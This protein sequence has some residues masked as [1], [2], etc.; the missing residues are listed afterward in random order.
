[1]GKTAFLFPGQGSQYVGM[2]SDLFERFPVARERFVIADAV[3]GFFLSE[4]M[5]GAGATEEESAEALKQ[6][7]V[8]Q[9][10]L[11]VHSLA[12]ASVLRSSGMVPQM[13]AGHSL[14]EYSALASAGAITFEAGLEVVRLR[15]RLMADAG[16]RRSGTMAAILGLEDHDVVNLC[17]EATESPDSVVE[18]ANFNSAGQV[19]ISGDVSAVE[20][21]M[22]LAKERGAK[23]VVP[24]T[25]SGAFHSPLMDYARD[26]LA[27]ALIKLDI[28]APACPIYLNVTAEPTCDPEEIRAR[29]L[30]QLMAPVRWSQTM[31]RMQADGATRFIEVGAG[32]VLTGLARRSL[33]RDKEILTAG[34]AE[35]MDALR[36]SSEYS[37]Q[38]TR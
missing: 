27:A 23:R 29:L 17:L 35:E 2:G 12:A 37:V 26:G 21:A 33:G 9:P 38:S 11:Y 19:V 34:K 4:I 20:R 8:T 25:V 28:A 7:D 18:P 6:T 3:L 5:F 14:G 31:L 1:M 32:N 24:L 36:A 16:Q 15:G 10:A 30:E 13:A 22:K